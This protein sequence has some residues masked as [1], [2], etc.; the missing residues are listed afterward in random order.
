MVEVAGV[1]TAFQPRVS[2]FT[3]RVCESKGRKLQGYAPIMAGRWQEDLKS[4]FGGSVIAIQ[5]RGAGVLSLTLEDMIMDSSPLKKIRNH[6]V[7][8]KLRQ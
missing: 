3:P 4:R 2:C 7:P 6:R 1:E 8:R 5:R